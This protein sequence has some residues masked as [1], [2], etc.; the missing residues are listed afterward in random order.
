MVVFLGTSVCV[1]YTPGHQHMTV[2]NTWC[3]KKPNVFT[4]AACC[5]KWLCGCTRDGASKGGLTECSCLIR[6]LS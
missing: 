3:V 1:F 4:L 5:L 6:R 2:V